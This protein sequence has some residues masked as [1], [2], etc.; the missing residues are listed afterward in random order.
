M[1]KASCIKNLDLTLHDPHSFFP[2]SHTSDA[3]AIF[4][5]AKR[6]IHVDAEDIKI[7]LIKNVKKV[8][9]N[10]SQKY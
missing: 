6:K 4:F 7:D 10:N 2:M 3:V 9:F 1:K 5:H 8:F